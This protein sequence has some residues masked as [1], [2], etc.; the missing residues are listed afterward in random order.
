MLRDNYRLKK[1]L[2]AILAALIILFT[3][4]LQFLHLSSCSCEHFHHENFSVVANNVLNIAVRNACKNNRCSS[5]APQRNSHH[6]HDSKNCPV[7][8][9]YSAIYAG[10]NVPFSSN[11]LLLSTIYVQESVKIQS[12]VFSAR[13][14]LDISPRAPPVI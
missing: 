12:D 9:T 10:F 1:F 4:L 2:P 6:Q 3:P 8:Q 11:H 7:C 13:I 14:P 5:S